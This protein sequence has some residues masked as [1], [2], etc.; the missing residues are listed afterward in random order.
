M[1]RR[2]LSIPEKHKQDNHFLDIANLKLIEKI[3]NA[4]SQFN[5]KKEDAIQRN[6][7]RKKDRIKTNEDFS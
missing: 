5:F 1:N 7:M 6:T 2:I 4:K 3:V